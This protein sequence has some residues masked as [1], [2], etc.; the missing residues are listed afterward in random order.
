MT[1]RIKFDELKAWQGERAEMI[2]AAATGGVWY[3]TLDELLT[4]LGYDRERYNRYKKK[5]EGGGKLAKGKEVKKVKDEKKTPLE[6]LTGRAVTLQLQ[7]GTIISGTL[8]GV[9]D[10]FFVVSEAEIIGAKN[11]CKTALVLIQKHYVVFLHLK[12]EVKPKEES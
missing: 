5:K 11:V 6:L 4:L 12:G 2:A 3:G 1:L 10:N 8:A 7:K 9:H